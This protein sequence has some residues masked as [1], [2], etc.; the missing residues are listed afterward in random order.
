MTLDREP[1]SVAPL[2]ESCLAIV[3]DKAHARSIELRAEVDATLGAIDADPRKLKQIVVNLLSNAVKFTDAGGRVAMT[4]R[5][6]DRAR[7]DP[8]VVGPGRVMLAPSVGDRA[9]I[10]IAVQDTGI[11]IAEADLARLFRPLMQVDASMKRRH[12]GTG[13]GLA[14][15]RRLFD[16]HGGGLA[17]DSALGRGSRFT[18]WLP[19]RPVLQAR[20]DEGVAQKEGS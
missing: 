13:L 10:E 12:D 3:R 11:G 1:V 5:R 15:V 18:V 6:I 19:Y 7:I 8:A 9:F 2:L 14:L 4:L 17:V 20:Q 16:L